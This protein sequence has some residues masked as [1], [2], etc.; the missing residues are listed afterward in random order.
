VEGVCLLI[1]VT[2]GATPSTFTSAVDP[3]LFSVRVAFREVPMFLMVPPFKLIA[4]PTAMP[5]LSRSPD[6]TVY[7]NKS[8][9]VPLPET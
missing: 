5:L 9:L 1:E 8:A 7:R 3:T 2:V 4:A 6:V